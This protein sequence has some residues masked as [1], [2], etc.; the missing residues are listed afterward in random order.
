MITTNIFLGTSLL[1]L[2]SEDADCLL[3]DD[4]A[5][6]DNDCENRVY[7]FS[8]SALIANI[9]VVQG[10][11][12]A[13]LAPLLGAIIDYTDYRREIGQLTVV[14]AIVISAAQIGTV[15]STW[16][17]MAILQ[18]FVGFVY[19]VQYMTS[20]AYFPEITTNLGHEAAN[21]VNKNSYILYF[22]SQIVVIALVTGASTALGLDDV[23]TAQVS[24]AFFVLCGLIF[25]VPSWWKYLPKVP[26]RH[27]LPT[28]PEGKPQQRLLTAGF[29][30]NWHTC[31][32]L[33]KHYR[34]GLFWY[35]L[36]TTIAEAGTTSFFPLT[37]SYLSEAL[38]FNGTEIGLAFLC[39]LIGSIPGSWVA[40]RVIAATNPNF[41]MKG[42]LLT[43]AAATTSGVFVM[44]EERPEMA[45]VWGFIWGICFGWYYTVQQI[46]FAMA[47]PQGQEAELTGFLVYCQLILS[48]LPPLI[49]SFMVEAGAKLEYALLILDVFQIGGALLL[50]PIRSWQEVLDEAQ[51]GPGLGHRVG[52]SDAENV[53]DPTT[54]NDGKETPP[55]E[56]TNEQKNMDEH[57]DGSEA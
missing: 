14:I 51:N 21:V 18:A 52:P 20:L 42:A 6:I 49:F 4:E 5:E 10:L 55:V 17:I 36:M 27:K 32:A 50:L 12:S 3:D 1:Y 33:Y 40:A 26:A 22:L 19:E 35:F 46:F 2:A 23:S 15:S 56:P 25:F 57:S 38:G 39:A 31:K 11:L 30:Q 28:T 9:A 54:Y 53:E 7:G 45:Y 29:A 47:V 41:A 48:W 43:F 13:F 16:F 37:I 34:K 8:P 24:Q 44:S